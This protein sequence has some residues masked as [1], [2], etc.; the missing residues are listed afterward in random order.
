MLYLVIS[1]QARGVADDA[2]E[3]DDE[4]GVF[5]SE[6]SITFIP[7]GSEQRAALLFIPGGMVEPRAYAPLL[8][9]VAESGHAAVLIRLPSL[10]GRHAMGES[11]RQE[12]VARARSVMENAPDRSWI[13]A[14]HSVGGHLAARVV[15]ADP[16]GAA[17]LVLIGTTHPRDFSLADYTGPVVKIHGT[18]DRIAPLERS[19]Q[20]AGNL[21]D[22]A[23]WVAIEGGNHSQ[24]GY[25]GFQL[26]DGR[27][28][29]T[30]E[31]QQDEV[32]GVL[33]DV[34][35][36]GA[37]AGAAGGVGAGAAAGV[38]AGAGAGADA[39]ADTAQRSR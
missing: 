8:R 6:S 9:R 33:L 26:G 3:T 15:Q 29:I 18:R 36:R 39:A 19:Q 35:S 17:G 23:E 24:F 14:G 34:L 28:Q 20:N 5:E 30:R 16:V 4:V 10:G 2:M 13:V 31:Q 25:Y 32:L 12:A 38:G 37:G 11:G 21:P 7:R 27:A 22:A 1:Y